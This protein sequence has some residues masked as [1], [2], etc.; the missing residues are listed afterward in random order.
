MRKLKLLSA[1]GLL[2]AGGLLYLLFR[3]RTLLLFCVA[4]A[5]GAAQVVDNWRTATAAWHLPAFMVNN[6]PGGLWAASYML[7]VDTLLVGKP[8]RARLAAVSVIP[9]TGVASE[10]L[11]ALHLLPG[12]PDLADAV[13]YLAPLL[14]YLS[15]HQTIINRLWETF[16]QTSN[17][18]SLS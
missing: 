3:P 2:L 6:L 17:S 10:L 7:I 13:C 8:W 4:D 9:L 5:M 14:L 16:S 15:H 11:Q 18:P 1:F 12:T